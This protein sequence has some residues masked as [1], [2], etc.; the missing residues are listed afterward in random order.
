LRSVRKAVLFLIVCLSFTKALAQDSTS[1]KRWQATLALGNY[2]NYL[3]VV[4]YPDSWRYTRHLD[5][6][7]AGRLYYQPRGR[8]FQV[9]ALADFGHQKSY[10]L[11]SWTIVSIGPSVRFNLS[12]FHWFSI[13]SEWSLAADWVRI[14]RKVESNHCS[15]CD[16]QPYPVGTYSALLADVRTNFGMRFTIKKRYVIDLRSLSISIISADPFLTYPNYRSGFSRRLSGFAQ[17]ATMA[18]A[19]NFNQNSINIKKPGH[20]LPGFFMLM[21]Q[22]SNN[23]RWPRS[24]SVDRRN[25]RRCSVS[26][27]LPR[28]PPASG[29][30]RLSYGS[31]SE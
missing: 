28:K 1:L 20:F 4:P 16:E 11:A 21:E 27:A 24:R 23:P 8:W 15:A 13:Y 5:P 26:P 29:S 22:S 30:H 9:G 12:P 3:Y 7:L 17:P 6:Y 2:N 31:P 19:L 10:N 25:K 18:S 14:H